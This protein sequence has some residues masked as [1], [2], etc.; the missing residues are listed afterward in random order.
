MNLSS[1]SPLAWCGIGSI[2]LVVISINLWLLSLLRHRGTSPSESIW[3]RTT[4][5]LRDPFAREAQALNELSRR[6]ASLRESSPEDHIRP[7]PDQA[8]KTPQQTS[9][10][11]K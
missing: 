11:I 9:S 10:Q 7:H 5:A 3:K 6:V 4:E 1:L 8:Q 2:L